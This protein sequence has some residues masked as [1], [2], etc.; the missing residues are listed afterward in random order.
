ML[1]YEDNQIVGKLEITLDDHK[2]ISEIKDI[3]IRGKDETLYKYTYKYDKHGNW[4][5]RI[6]HENGNLKYITERT[7]EYY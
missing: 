1:R 2:N 5:E 6:K 3:D 7:I 4:I